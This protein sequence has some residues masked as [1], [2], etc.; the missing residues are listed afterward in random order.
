MLARRIK[1]LNFFENYIKETKEMS[2][3]PQKLAKATATN[4]SLEIDRLN[5]YTA[6]LKTQ[7]GKQK[8]II[9]DLNLQ[10]G[11]Y[12]DENVGLRNE[13]ADREGDVEEAVSEL[14]NIQAKLY[15]TEKRL[16]DGQKKLKL[17]YIDNNSLR[18]QLAWYKKSYETAQI[19]YLNLQKQGIVKFTI[20][21][22][23]G[24]IR[25]HA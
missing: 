24:K 18:E 5:K 8:E 3:E 14:S 4:K 2:L 11:A 17:A 19:N 22:V 1:Q 7:I 21:K 15:T 9:T 25:K 10:L 23:A 16:I 13:L 20:S 6:R 12:D